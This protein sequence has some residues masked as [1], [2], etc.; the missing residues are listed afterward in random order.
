MC[1]LFRGKR[2][3]PLL[4]LLKHR[5]KFSV[6]STNVDHRRQSIYHAYWRTVWPL[7]RFRQ[8]PSFRCRTPETTDHQ[9]CGIHIQSGQRYGCRECAQ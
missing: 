4:S 2:I 3:I 6:D 8:T 5:F 9:G 7:G 1:Y